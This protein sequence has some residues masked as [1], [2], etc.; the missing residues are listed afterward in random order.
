MEHGPSDTLTW[1]PSFQNCAK[2]NFVAF[3]P[4]ICGNSLQQP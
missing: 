2:I 4:L 1:T 3:S